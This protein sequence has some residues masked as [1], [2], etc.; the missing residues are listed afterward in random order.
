MKILGEKISANV[1]DSILS[2]L[3][4]QLFFLL[5]GFPFWLGNCS[6]QTMKGFP[7]SKRWIGSIRLYIWSTRQEKRPW[8]GQVPW[9]T[10]HL[11]KKHFYDFSPKHDMSEG[12][13]RFILRSVGY[14]FCFLCVKMFCYD[15]NINFTSD[16]KIIQCDQ[17]ITKPR[18]TNVFQH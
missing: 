3:E 1:F 13:K 11:R 16:R 6:V 8:S 9:E 10:L 15:Y 12:R 2:L 14:L 5:L 4:T 18:W 17:L 7:I